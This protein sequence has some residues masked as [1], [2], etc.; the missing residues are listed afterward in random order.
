MKKCEVDVKKEE[1]K[2]CSNKQKKPGIFG[3]IAKLSLG[4]RKFRNRSEHFAT[5]EKFSLCE[6]FARLAKF[7]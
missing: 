5:L 1:C 4:L 3:I 2:G 6:N 7:R